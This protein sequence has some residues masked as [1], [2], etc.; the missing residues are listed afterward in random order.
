MVAPAVRAPLV[1]GLD[2]GRT[3]KLSGLVDQE[4]AC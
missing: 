4:G 2:V 1:I 3:R